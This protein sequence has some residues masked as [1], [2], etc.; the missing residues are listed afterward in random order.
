MTTRYSSPF[1]NPQVCVGPLSERSVYP[2]D[3]GIQLHFPQEVSSAE[4]KVKY[5]LWKEGT[6]SFSNLLLL[7]GI[8]PE[9]LRTA[10]GSLKD[11]KEISQTSAYSAS[12][13]SYLYK[14][15]R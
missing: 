14:L 9:E 8:R 1:A 12:G 3:I 4:E 15:S 13:K 5:T 10:L 2:R 6:Q 11:D 7:T